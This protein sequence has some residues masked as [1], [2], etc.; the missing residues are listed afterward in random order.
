MRTATV[1]GIVL[2]GLG[3]LSLVWFVSPVNFLI[4]E[5]S[6]QQEMNL[7]L[8]LLGAVALVG[9]VALLAAVLPRVDKNKSEP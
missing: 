5:S 3:I 7:T 9:G 2:I 4:E 8:P 6:N 1:V